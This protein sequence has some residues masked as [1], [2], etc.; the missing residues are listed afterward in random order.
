MFTSLADRLFVETPQLVVTVVIALILVG[1][2]AAGQWARKLV[3]KRS[4]QSDDADFAQAT[5]IVSSVLG[6]VA[7]LVGFTFSL[8]VNGYDKRRSAV[9]DEA[10]AIYSTYLAAQPLNEPSRTQIA[11]ML[12]NYAELRIDAASPHRLAD[13]KL[14]IGR[15][16]LVQ[17][18]LWKA[19]L[20]TEG[21]ASSPASSRLVTEV[22]NLIEVGMRRVS[23][24]QSTVP[25]RIHATLILFAAIGS[26]ALGFGFKGGAVRATTVLLVLF[27]ISLSLITDIERPTRGLVT[28]S[29]QP[30]EH[31]RDRMAGRAASGD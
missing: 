24:R 30:M 4:G 12:Q 29:Q 8:A 6:L 10:D 7:L 19:A 23:I 26:F 3:H 16:E 15:S 22:H 20:A 31:V 25:G 21:N 2:H 18:A 11:A 9:I 13:A 5:F 28:E 14:L 27:T 17:D 1:A